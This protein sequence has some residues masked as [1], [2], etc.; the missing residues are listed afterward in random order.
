MSF[1]V[2][3]SSRKVNMILL[4]YMGRAMIKNHKVASILDMTSASLCDDMIS[5]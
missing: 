1:T 4:R 2:D 5:K 3:Y